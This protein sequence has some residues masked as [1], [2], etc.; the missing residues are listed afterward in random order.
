MRFGWEAAIAV[1]H[2][3]AVPA[4]HCHLVNALQSWKSL[5]GMSG[6]YSQIGEST[7]K[8]RADQS[9]NST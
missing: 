4:V 7:Q 6:A 2:T 9:A 8:L 5:P 1:S 3:I